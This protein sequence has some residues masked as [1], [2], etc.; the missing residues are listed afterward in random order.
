MIRRPFIAALNEVR[1]SRDADGAIIEYKDRKVGTVHLK[2]GDKVAEMTDVEILAAHNR[3]LR[4]IEENRMNYRH[5]AVEMPPGKKQIQYSPQ[6]DQWT[7][8]GEVLRC[9]ISDGGPNCE[10]TVSIDEQELSLDEFGRLLL[11][12]A[13]WGMR[14]IFVPHDEIG[15]QPK[16]RVEMPRR[17]SKVSRN[18]FLG[19]WR[20]TAMELWEQADVDLLGI[21][22]IEFGDD[23]FGDFRFCAVEGH[24]DCRYGMREG[25]P[26]VEFSWEGSDDSEE[27]SGRG[28]A[29]V[30]DGVLR[31]R[32]YFHVGD[33]SVFSA[34]KPVKRRALKATRHH[35][36]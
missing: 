27:A 29:I 23:D 11:T 25:L 36:Q 34:E 28:W 33:E 14:V 7:P 31:G 30:E 18:P 16:I 12:Y 17:G 19:R 26:L 4:S 21:G 5:V 24:L 35:S 13:G 3:I 9:L 15:F 1:I 32:I 8:R 10:A 2:L 20:I 22:F 6:S